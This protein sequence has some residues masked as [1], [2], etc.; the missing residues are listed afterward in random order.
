M[1]LEVN[2]GTRELAVLPT[3][4]LVRRWRDQF[5]IDVTSYFR[6]IDVVRVVESEKSGLVSFEPS[7]IG[8]EALYRTLESQDWYYLEDKW[9]HRRSLRSVRPGTRVLEVGCGRGA[10][11][12]KAKELGAMVTG[13]ELNAAAART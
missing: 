13:I 12:V 9:E 5:D 1:S 7:V 4:D 11:L 2:N 10:F 3:T 6:G 8:D